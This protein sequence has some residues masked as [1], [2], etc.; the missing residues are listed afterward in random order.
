V[1][2]VMGE[3]GFGQVID[4]VKRDCGCHYAMKVMQKEMMKQNLGSSWRKKI[5]SEQQIMTQLHHPFMV[6]LKYSF[7]NSD[8]LIL[9]MD[10][11]S[12]GDL[13][14]FVL[15]KKRLAAE[16]VKWALMEVTEVMSYMHSQSILYR[17]LK[18]ENL[19]IDDEGHI[20]LIDMGLAARFD[21]K[22]GRNSRV[23]TDCYMA[24]EVRFAR[25]R[26][27][28]YGKS[29]DWYTVGVL[30]YEFTHGA[31]PFTGRDAETPIYRGG[32]FPTKACKA[33]CEGMLAQ[34]WKRR[35][36]CG[37]SGDAEIKQHEY[38]E[39]VDWDIVAACKIP[40]PMK[41]VKGVPKKKK[42]KEMQAQRTAG[43][44]A[45]ADKTEEEARHHQEYTIDSWN[46]VSPTVVSEEYMESVYQC[47]S[48]I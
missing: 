15:T 33:L 26:R 13:S 12:S 2:R 48:A 11:I 46:F 41:G 34:D 32:E 25:R 27:Q 3:G 28:A 8:F 36:G 37:P 31:L 6:N 42:D 47:V 30:L 20:R 45:D 23:G 16:Q 10:L 40:S 24:P 14:E 29:A 22:A 9:V 1:I 5:A 38:F 21:P 35:I 44:I 43:E 19:L 7:Q 39:G 17:D 18:P 4:V